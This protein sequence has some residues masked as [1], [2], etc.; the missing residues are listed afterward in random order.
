MDCNM[1]K[2][3]KIFWLSSIKVSYFV[4]SPLI[5]V[6]IETGQ[7]IFV[8]NI[9]LLVNFSGLWIKHSK[10]EKKKKANISEL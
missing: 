7:K 9:H 3:V 10:E 5:S 8:A 2:A 4:S 1:T 6:S